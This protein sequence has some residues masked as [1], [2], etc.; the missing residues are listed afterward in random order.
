VSTK[1]ISLPA[2]GLI[3]ALGGSMSLAALPAANAA[4]PADAPATQTARHHRLPSEHVDARI[5]YLKTALKVTDAQEAQWDKVATAMREN[6]KAMDNVVKQART[7]RKGNETA[8]A[9]LQAQTQ[10]ATTRAQNAERFLAAFQPLYNSLSDTQKKAADEVM[11]PHR[12]RH[13]R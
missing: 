9:R 2:L 11:A 3:A 7:G 4:A 8:L 5:S 13:R 6:A 10:F 1:K 12:H